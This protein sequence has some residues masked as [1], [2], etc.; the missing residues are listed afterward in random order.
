MN[1]ETNDDQLWRIA[2]KR[3]GFKQTFLMYIIVNAILVGIWYFTSGGGLYFWPKWPILGWGIGL[4]IQYFE[5]YHGGVI[6]SAQQEYDALKRN[7]KP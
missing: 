2:K 1:N 7:Q 4:A 5:A 6:F 3:A